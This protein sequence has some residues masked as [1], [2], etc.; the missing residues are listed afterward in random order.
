MDKDLAPYLERIR[1][2][3]PGLALSTV[4]FNP[5]GL[6]ND[7]LIVNNELVFRFPKDEVGRENLRREGQLLEVV[8]RYVT[9][10]K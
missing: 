6:A 5:D 1:V 10:A 8:R 9:L 3:L 2:C 7:V 4:R